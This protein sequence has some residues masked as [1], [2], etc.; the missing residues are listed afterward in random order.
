MDSILPEDVDLDD[1]EIEDLPTNTFLVDNEQVA[2]MN[3]GLEAMRQAVEIILNVDRFGYQIY[4]SNFGCELEDLVGE[5]SDYI[6]SVFPGRIRDAFSIDDRILR[7]ENYTFTTVGD[8]MTI[9]F[10]VVT[11]FGTFTQEVEV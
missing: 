9:T 6:E 2:G 4:T 3:D 5:S 11:V 1:V 7:E 10:D 8:T